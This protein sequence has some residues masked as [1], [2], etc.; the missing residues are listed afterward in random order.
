MGQR[1]IRCKKCGRLF[2]GKRGLALHNRHG[3]QDNEK[4]SF[5][6]QHVHHVKN[7][8]TKSDGEYQI[9]KGKNN[10]TGKNFTGNNG[11]QTHKK[12]DEQ[13][14]RKK[15][16]LTNEV[17]SQVTNGH[18]REHVVQYKERGDDGKVNLTLQNEGQGELIGRRQSVRG[19]RRQVTVWR[20]NQCNASF[21]YKRELNLHNRT[22]HNPDHSVLQPKP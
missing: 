1:R 17:T 7:G 8:S 18:V 2:R 11:S 22:L 15:D 12:K 10:L 3:C 6:E 21:N 20:C 13:N 14:G 16:K 4:V 19:R 9:E 5:K